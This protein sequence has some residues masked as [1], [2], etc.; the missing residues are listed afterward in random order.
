ML[1]S[2]ALMTTSHK[3]IIIIITIITII[4]MVMMIIISLVMEQLQIHEPIKN[5]FHPQFNPSVHMQGHTL[6]RKSHTI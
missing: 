2:F 1:I 3:I 5:P 6:S 4:I